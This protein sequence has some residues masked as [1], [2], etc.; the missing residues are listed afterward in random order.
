[1]LKYKVTPAGA[2]NIYNTSDPRNTW[3]GP[4]YQGSDGKYHCYNP[5]YNVGSLGGPPTIMHG[6]AESITGPWDWTSQQHICDKCGENPAFVAFEEKGKMVYTLWVGGAIWKAT[7]PYGPFTKMEGVSYPGGNPAPVFHKGAFYLTNQKTTEVLTTTLPLSKNWT[8]FATI[9]HPTRPPQWKAEDPFMWIDKNENWYA[10]VC[11]VI[12]QFSFLCNRRHIINHAYD[13][14]QYE[15]CGTS[16]ASDHFFSVDGKD[17]HIQS[18]GGGGVQNG[19]G[20]YGHTVQY[21]DGTSHTFTTL[22]RPNLHFDSNGQL[23]HI[24]LAVDLVTG[25]EGCGNR[26]KHAHFGHTPCDNCKWDDH[27][28]TT[29]IA[30]D[31]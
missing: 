5:L 12:I 21:D 30:L 28:G 29:V 18:V 10:Y 4:I 7:T 1:V 11:M 8:T 24:N 13:N 19:V 23:T 22:E 16:T 3:N 14:L 2:K 9:A 6:I 27:A 25:D 17:W 31:V 20:P 15:N 26:T